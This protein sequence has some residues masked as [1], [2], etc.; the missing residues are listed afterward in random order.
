MVPQAGEHVQHLAL[1]GRGVSDA[2]GGEEG[3]TQAAR[4][5]GHRL[6]ARLLDGVVV[7][8]QLGVDVLAAEDADEPLRFLPRL[9]GPAPHERLGQ[10]AVVAAGQ[11]DE[12]LGVLG[13]L[14]G[15]GRPLA[16]LRPQL[17]EADEAAEALVAGPVAGEQRPAPGALHRDL[18]PDVGPDPELLG[19][20]VEARGAVDAVAVDER[21]R[22]HAVVGADLGHLLGQRGALEEAE[23][24]A[25][26]QLDVHGKRGGRPVFAFSSLQFDS[27]PE[28]RGLSRRAPVNAPGRG[29]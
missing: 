21:Q 29:R 20:L 6:V 2:V 3:E 18:G 13:H 12:P 19:R 23:G 22:P 11:A 26:V 25:G 7:P 28:R 5:L 27:G 17:V 15:G 4:D 9:A 1:G 10:G 14:F 8:L 24:G 16:L